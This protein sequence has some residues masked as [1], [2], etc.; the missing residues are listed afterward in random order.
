MQ[1]LTMAAH[2]KP[3]LILDHLPKLL[4][5]VYEQTKFNSAL[6]R[7]VCASAAPPRLRRSALQIP[8]SIG[9]QARH[10]YSMGRPGRPPK[11]PAGTA[12]GIST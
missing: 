6:V 4:P 5:L 10:L 7:R 9:A 11:A 1:T 3:G 8:S 12:V 2:N